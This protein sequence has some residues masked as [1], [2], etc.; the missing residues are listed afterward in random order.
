MFSLIGSYMD[1]QDIKISTISTTQSKIINWTQLQPWI[2]QFRENVRSHE[3]YR[4]LEVISGDE[5]ID[6]VGGEETVCLVWEKGDFTEGIFHS[7][8]TD[9]HFRI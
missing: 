4:F 7:L 9:T 5:F 2:H 3:E 8:R 6:G 1:K